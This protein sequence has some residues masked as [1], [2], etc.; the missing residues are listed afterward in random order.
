VIK[1][2]YARLLAESAYAEA[3]GGTTRQEP[4]PA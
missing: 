1:P 3:T 4:S 2:G